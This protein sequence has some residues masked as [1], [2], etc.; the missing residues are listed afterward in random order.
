MHS[1]RPSGTRRALY[2]VF[3]F[4]YQLRW[5]FASL[6]WPPI[7]AQS[8]VWPSRLGHHRRYA[9][10]RPP[11]QRA[12]PRNEEIQ[13]HFV[14]VV[15][16]SGKL[17]PAIALFDALKTLDRDTYDLVQ[18]SS[19]ELDPVMRE[20][21][22]SICKVFSRGELRAVERAK[23]KPKK[24]PDQLAKQLEINWAIDRHDLQ[25]RLRRLADFL[26]QGRRVEILLARR[27]SGRQATP[28][29]ASALV[30]KL[31]MTCEEAGGKEWKGMEGRI[32][33]MAKLHFEGDKDKTR[34]AV[35]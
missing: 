33:L 22:P 2:E 3:V 29:E 20:R 14:R 32:G 5:R 11:V 24:T 13:S 8:P 19:P 27:K 6:V 9:Q 31:K 30:E 17:G 26:G 16:P 25:H 18:V 28:D 34:E 23:A 7:S 4:P 12:Q 15:D 21:N 35:A 1:P 10:Y